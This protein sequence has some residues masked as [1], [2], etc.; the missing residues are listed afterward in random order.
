[1]VLG[2]LNLEEYWG[3]K[4]K[5]ARVIFRSIPDSS[6]R[7][8]AFLAKEIDMM[9]QPTPDQLA[10]IRARRPDVKVME[11]PGMNVAY[12]AFNVTKKPFD[13][14]K[15]RRA[16]NMAVNKDAIIKGIYSGM[17]MA[18]VN[19]IPP[20]LWAFNKDVK[21]YAYNTAEAKKLLTEAGFPNGFSTT[22]YFMP[23][24]RPYM[25]DG[26]KVAEAI[27]ADLQAIGVTVQLSTY[28]WA[29]YL[30]KTKNGAHEMALLGWSGDNGDP[31][32]FLHI[33][34]SG[35]NAKAPAANIAFYS[36]DKVT[37][38]LAKGKTE[39]VQA[40]RAQLYKDAQVQ[41]HADAP[42]I[43]LAHSRVAMP[44]DPK[45]QGYM[46]S[47]NETRRFNTVWIKK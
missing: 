34:L 11:A 39:P 27:Q 5:V 12:L 1:M 13:N 22:L 14:S 25:P 15:V 29:T 10:T 8:N 19:P 31:D 23:V 20:S 46:M 38:L 2:P 28:E 47:P 32:N 3:E 16:L 17:G 21:P 45:V 33:L 30:D 36:N 4:A 26:K 43:P 40:K 35:D 41:I 24:S 7:L 6:A 18:A 44:M 42:W 9:N 37:A